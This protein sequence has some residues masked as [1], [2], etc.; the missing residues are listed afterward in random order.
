LDNVIIIKYRYALSQYIIKKRTAT[1]I[2]E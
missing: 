2:D 1:I